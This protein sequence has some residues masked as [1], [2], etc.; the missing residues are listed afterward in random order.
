MAR[1][2]SR[3]LLSIIFSFADK[4][5]SGESRNII[6]VFEL[7]TS[8]VTSEIDGLNVNIWLRKPWG[9]SNC[10]V[11]MLVWHLLDPC[12]CDLSVWKQVIEKIF[13]RLW[14]RLEKE[15]QNYW[16]C[17]RVNTKTSQP[18]VPPQRCKSSKSSRK[19]IKDK[20]DCW[21]NE[22]RLTY[23]QSTGSIK[24]IV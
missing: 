9:D 7:P 23:W 8:R 14:R 20:G 13:H 10:T 21:C 2:P 17:T 6:P 4:S 11:V 16:Q 1:C 12:W 15:S 19:K 3:F 22:Q 24:A 5:E 18:A